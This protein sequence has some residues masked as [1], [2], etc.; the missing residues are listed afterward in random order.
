ME[1]YKKSFFIKYSYKTIF[2][3]IKSLHLAD[4]KFEIVDIF[5][6]HGANNFVYGQRELHLYKTFFCQKKK[7][8]L[9]A[10]SLWKWL[11]IDLQ[12]AGKIVLLSTRYFAV[13]KIVPWI[14]LSMDKVAYIQWKMIL[15]RQK[16]RAQDKHILSFS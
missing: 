6:L 7:I 14:F 4:L 9:L 10:D 1:D 16:D 2:D 15:S 12:A 3:S 5:L 13:D 8:S 11:F